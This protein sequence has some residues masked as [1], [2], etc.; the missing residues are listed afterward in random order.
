MMIAVATTFFALRHIGGIDNL[1]AEFPGDSLLGNNVNY[2]AL[3]IVWMVF[4]FFKQF[5]STNNVME[6]TRYL[7]AKDNRNARKAALMAGILFL[8]GPVLWFIPPMV[9][10]VVYPDLALKF[11]QLGSKASEAAYVAIAIDTLPAGMLGLLMAGMFAATISSMDSGLNRN[12]GIFVKNFYLSILRPGASEAEQMLVSRIVTFLV[13]ILVVSAALWYSTL[14]NLGLFD[15]M[16]QFGSLIALPVVIP[17]VLGLVVRRTPDWA[18][19]S[20]VLVGLFCSY[21]VKFQ[22]GHAWAQQTFGLQFSA[23][24][25]SDY[26]TALGIAANVIIP[27]LW[28]FSTRLFHRGDSG[29]RGKELEAYW[30]N[31]ARPVMASESGVNSDARQGKALGSLAAFYGLFVLLLFLLPNEPLGR[32]MYIFCG[33]TLILIGYALYR[34]TRPAAAAPA[35]PPAA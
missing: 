31:L 24:E 4:I 32:L 21:L 19:W 26:D 5:V 7:T 15:L 23:R 8:V 16:L 35:P 27:P 12:A 34:S 20:T 22:F 28:F 1:I 30:D 3:V 33:G 14:E 11:P 18:G 2:P 6:A 10:A 9:S 13:G 29:W 17:L 25:M